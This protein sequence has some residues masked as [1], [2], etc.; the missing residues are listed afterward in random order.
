MS[1]G[2]LDSVY[3][4]LKISLSYD[5]TNAEALNDM[6]I[7]ELKRSNVDAALNNFR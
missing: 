6:G 1:L 3:R 5:G 4:A 7:L 2:E